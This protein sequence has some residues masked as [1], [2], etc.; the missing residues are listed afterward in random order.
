MAPCWLDMVTVHRDVRTKEATNCVL[1]LFKYFYT[2]TN[3]MYYN[4][5]IVGMGLLPPFWSPEEGGV[6]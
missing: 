1:F 6:V 4:F 2:Q 3:Y 5:A